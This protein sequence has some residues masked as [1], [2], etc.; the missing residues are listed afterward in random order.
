MNINLF[1]NGDLEIV[2]DNKSKSNSYN[3]VENIIKEKFDMFIKSIYE[4]NVIQ[5]HF[6]FSKFSKINE[7]NVLI[8]DLTYT[9]EYNYNGNAKNLNKILD[10]FSGNMEYIFKVIHNSSV[11]IAFDFNR[12]STY[13]RKVP[14]MLVTINNKLLTVYVEQVTDIFLMDTISNYFTGLINIIDKN[15]EINQSKIVT[16]KDIDE[17]IINKEKYFENFVDDGTEEQNIIE[18]NELDNKHNEGDDEDDYFD[19]ES[20]GFSDT[21]EK[22]VFDNEIVESMDENIEADNPIVNSE[23]TIDKKNIED[24]KESSEDETESI[25][26]GYESDGS[27]FGGVKKYYDYKQQRIKSYDSKLFDK[28]KELENDISLKY[29]AFSKTCP[30]SEQRQPIILSK[31]EKDYI[32]SSFPNTYGNHYLEYSYDPKNPYYYICPRY[33][34]VE[35]NISLGEEHVK[36]DSNGNIVSEFCKDDGEYGT[37]ITADL[38]RQHRDK[39]D[40]NKYVYNRPGLGK[41]CVPCCFKQGN[42]INEIA[43]LDPSKPNEEKKIKQ[44]K[45]KIKSK[46]EKLLNP[47]PKCQL[48]NKSRETEDVRSTEKNNENKV[49]VQF[50]YIKQYDKFPL[51]KLQLGEISNPIKQFLHVNENYYRFGVENNKKQS[52]IACL[53]CIYA[54]ETNTDE[55]DIETFVKKVK[56]ITSFKKELIKLIDIDTYSKYHNGDINTMFNYGHAKT[57]NIKKYSYSKFYGKNEDTKYFERLVNSYEN[58]LDFIKDESSYINYHQLW[59]ITTYTIFKEKY[60]LIIIEYDNDGNVYLVCPENNY[61]YQLEKFN[62]RKSSIILL[63]RNEFFEPLFFYKK[64]VKQNTFTPIHKDKNL[65]KFFTNISYLYRSSS[66]CG[67]QPSINDGDNKYNYFYNTS[68]FVKDTLKKYDIK[69]IKQVINYQFQNIGFII[70]YKDYKLF[71]PNYP[72]QSIDGL[73]FIYINDSEMDKYIQKYSI[74][75]EIME[76]L[77]IKTNK[78]IPCKIKTK[79]VHKDKIVGVYTMSNE[80]IR[81]LPETNKYND[82]LQ[83]HINISSQKD[84]SHLDPYHIDDIISSKLKMKTYSEDTYKLIQNQNIYTLFKKRMLFILSK[85]PNKKDLLDI[86]R[87]N[88]TYNLNYKDKFSKIKEILIDMTKNKIGFTTKDQSI[89]KYFDD[90]TIYNEFPKNH[91]LNKSDNETNFYNKLADEMIRYKQMNLFYKLPRQYVSNDLYNF[92]LSG[93]EIIT[94]QSFLLQD[95]YFNHNNYDL[96]LYNDNF[97]LSQPV[98]SVLYSNEVVENDI[99]KSTSIGINKETNKKVYLEFS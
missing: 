88:N 60:N 95:D 69:I 16:L 76:S 30:T 77:Y 47:E 43:K 51:G 14:K 27:V 75:V 71:L 7:S 58:F 82:K 73:N 32:D 33:W 36:K 93:N 21:S 86:I 67:V 78:E 72:T 46:E 52:Y 79:M 5:S 90:I 4:L 10:K 54:F 57:I 12:I 96:K 74:V 64:D 1:E 80:F 81:T 6:K 13:T 38:Q 61:S 84:G 3:E 37:I 34:C 62:L 22:S 11:N 40:P 89:E 92:N 31:E 56:S 99:M 8:N 87:I 28:N 25:G 19:N 50:N 26:L 83:N 24:K 41:S 23:Q 65:H 35:K 70:D 29:K 18:D 44:L 63:K 48:L 42:E 66:F 15:K 17:S 49:K 53:S 85:I 2:F 9:F 39:D 59:E 55:I 98:K 94:F 91:L 68:L 97:N 45:A 20:I